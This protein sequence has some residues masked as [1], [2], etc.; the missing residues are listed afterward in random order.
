MDSQGRQQQFAHVVGVERLSRGDDT[1]A[2]PSRNM[3]D[4]STAWAKRTKTIP[5]SENWVCKDIEAR[6]RLQG[7]FLDEKKELLFI[8]HI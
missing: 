7:N 3:Y 6:K 8:L 2:T 1:V 4:R 5:R